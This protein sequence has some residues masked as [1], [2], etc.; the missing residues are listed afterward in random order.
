MEE[1]IAELECKIDLL[2]KALE[3]VKAW[4]EVNNRR[5]SILYEIAD[6]AIKATPTGHGQPTTVLRR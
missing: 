4:C 3:K 2:V 1:R 6:A 5:R